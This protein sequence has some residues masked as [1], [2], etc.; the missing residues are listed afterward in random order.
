MAKLYRGKPIHGHMANFFDCVKDR[1]LPISDVFTHV[2]AMNACHTANIAM[3]LGRKVKWDQ[4]K[5]EFLGDDEANQ[6]TRRTQ[7]PPYTIEV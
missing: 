4:E 1:S 7:R 6:L 5:H 2:V 3:L